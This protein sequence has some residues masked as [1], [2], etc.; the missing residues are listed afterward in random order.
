M[1]NDLWRN[2]ISAE[3]ACDARSPEDLQSK[4]RDDSH[5]WIVTIKQ[6]SMVKIK[7]IGK[8]KVDDVDM[9]AGQV[10]SWLRG[11][12]RERDHREGHHLPSKM[13]RRG[14]HSDGTLTLTPHPK[15]QVTI[16]QPGTKGRKN[17]TLRDIIHNNA[18]KAAAVLVQDFL[19][20][21]PILAIETTDN[22]FSKIRE[23]PL[24]NPEKWKQLEQESGEKR[25]IQQIHDHLKAYQN[26]HNT[27][28]RSRDVFV[29]NSRSGSIFHYDVCN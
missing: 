5:S 15:Q 25:Y 4:Y 19:K 7:T 27:K 9:V 21:G 14:S 23:T 24:S 12:I 18:Q 29:F 8:D 13:A 3:L 10:V 6:D 1:L 17:I 11:Q 22:V 26:S 2:D 20:D 28:N 16:L